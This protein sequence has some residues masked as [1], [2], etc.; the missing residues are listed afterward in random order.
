[1]PR[2]GLQNSTGGGV[3]RKKKHTCLRGDFVF[4]LA[5][6]AEQVAE[7]EAEVGDLQREVELRQEQETAL[8]E[9]PSAFPSLCVF[10]LVMAPL[11]VR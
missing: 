9:V 3:C 1:M 11:H 4:H 7:L 8:K 6:H 2:R 5:V 10:L